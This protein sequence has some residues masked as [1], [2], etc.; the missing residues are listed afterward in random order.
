MKS[1]EK[2]IKSYMESMW[3]DILSDICGILYTAHGSAVITVTNVFW[4]VRFLFWQASIKI[5]IYV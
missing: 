5:C 2:S 4:L 3:L 1:H